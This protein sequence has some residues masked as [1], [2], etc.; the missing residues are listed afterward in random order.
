VG[1]AANA[2]ISLEANPGTVTQASLEGHRTAGVNRI[3]LGVQAF[4]PELLAACGRMHD[5]EAVY[6]AVADLRAAGFTNFNLDLI[7]G[8]PHQ[9][10]AHW[11]ESL[12]EV[13]AIAPAHVSLYDLTIE[14]GTRFGRWYRPGDTPLP[15][16]AETVEMYHEAIATLT[17][18]GYEHYE[19][20]NFARPGYQ[21]RHNRIYWENRSYHGL[22]MGATGYVGGRRYQQPDT[23]AAYFKLVDSGRWPTAPIATPAE[24]L[25][26][27]LMLGLRLR[28]GLDVAELETRFG[29]KA[30]ASILA[31]LAP[32]GDLGWVE[33]SRRDAGG[34]RLRL[35]P[36]EGWL[37]SNSILV[38]LLG[39]I[40]LEAI[41]ADTALLATGSPLID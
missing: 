3:S 17:A 32:F 24:Q 8:L 41:D 12:A 23:L 6:R 10:K 30:I 26:D 21:C 33:V 20:S 22:G 1:F 38:D 29:P 2:E 15:S 39:A 35:V 9:T 11:R 34:D 16:E 19:I 36:P 25:A 13:V 18:A 4:Q 28:E 7:F 40:D 31:V 37:F 27:T 5:V 14:S